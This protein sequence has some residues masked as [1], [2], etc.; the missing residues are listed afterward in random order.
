MSGQQF[1]EYLERF[2]LFIIPL[3]HQREWFRY[4]HLFTDLLR[5]HLRNTSSVEYIAGLYEQA[6]RWCENQGFNDE[7]MHYAALSGSQEQLAKLVEISGNTLVQSGQTAQRPRLIRLLSVETLR[8]NPGL[9]V[10]CAWSEILARQSPDLRQAEVY[11]QMAEQGVAEN[12][13]CVSSTGYPVAYR[14]VHTRAILSRFKGDAPETVIALTKKALELLPNDDYAYR[15]SL[16][17]NLGMA[18]LAVANLEEALKNLQ[19]SWEEARASG[20]SY[21]AIAATYMLCRCLQTQGRL[22]EMENLLRTAL[23]DF[24]QSESESRRIIPALGI[25]YIVQAWLLL[26]QAGSREKMDTAAVEQAVKKGLERCALT[27]EQ[28]AF[29]EGLALKARLLAAQGDLLGAYNCLEE[30]EAEIPVTASYCAAIRIRLMLAQNDNDARIELFAGRLPSKLDDWVYP[31]AVPP[32]VWHWEEQMGLVRLMIGRKRQS[33]A[34]D[35]VPVLSYLDRKIEAC[36]SAGWQMQRIELHLLKALALDADQ[37]TSSAAEELAQAQVAAE[38]HGFYR[39][40]V[41]EGEPFAD[42]LH[43]VHNRLPST[44]LLHRLIVSLGLDD[45][46]ALHANPVNHPAKERSRAGLVDPLTE[47]EFE[48]LKLIA[49][50]FSNKEIAEKLVVTIGTVKAHTSNIYRKLDV[51]GRTKALAKAREIHLI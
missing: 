21:V 41:E 2:N 17:Q 27:A 7:A 49:G 48:V 14:V 22:D 4:H 38:T 28:Y 18:Y 43:R 15:C 16:Y 33:T 30:M 12:P 31:V 24:E 20:M 9:C 29:A 1:L 5:H 19:Q 45:K 44:P 40:L 50:G 13:D 35:L 26:E 32:I 37:N 6:S 8:S 42:L 39:L 3:D 23:A 34:A 47:R 25:L 46:L 36:T 51:P 10:E 11:L